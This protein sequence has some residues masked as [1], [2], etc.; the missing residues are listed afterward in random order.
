[1]SIPPLRRIVLR[2]LGAGVRLVG[3]PTDDAPTADP[4]PVS[5]PDGAVEAALVSSTELAPQIE[6]ASA[7]AAARSG[8]DAS[9]VALAGALLVTW[10]DGSLGCPS[11]GSKYTQALVEGYLLTLEVRGERVAYHGALGQDP[12]LCDRD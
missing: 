2:G 7:D 5:V 11:E 8:I 1:M 10:S 6:A 9:E 4:T 12:F 3:C